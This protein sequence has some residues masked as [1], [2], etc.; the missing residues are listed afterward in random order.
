MSAINPKFGRELMLPYRIRN[1]DDGKALTSEMAI[2]FSELV[3][4]DTG[5][6][7]DEKIAMK[8]RSI[9]ILENFSSEAIK[10]VSWEV[11]K[12]FSPKALMFMPEKTR[13]AIS[14]EDRQALLDLAKNRIPTNR[15][16]N[17]EFNTKEGKV[18]REL[19]KS[20]GFLFVPE[21]GYIPPTTPPTTSEV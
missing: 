20:L 16:G 13:M 2:R 7:S 8:D 6:I 3:E 15:S 9:E 21:S 5:K 1:E 19:S 11:L 4:E 18:Y 14:F 17:P 12:N 10:K